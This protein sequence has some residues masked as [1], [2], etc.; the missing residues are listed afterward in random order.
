MFVCAVLCVIENYLA[1]AGLLLSIK[2]II[3]AQDSIES[4]FLTTVTFSGHAVALHYKLEGRGFDSRL[5]NWDFS[6]T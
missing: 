5:C 2:K 3:S 1:E 6:L 4:F